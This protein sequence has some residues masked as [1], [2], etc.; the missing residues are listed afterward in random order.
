MPRVIAISMAGI[1]EQANIG[2]VPLLVGLILVIML[3]NFIIP[4]IMPK[5]AI[6]APVFIPLFVQLGVAPQTVLAAYRIGD[7]PTNV[8][9]PLMVYFPFIALV[10][11]R[12]QKDAGV[13]SI[14]ALMLP[15]TIIMA[16]AWTIF[17]VI[18]FV[19]GIPLG[20][21]YPVVMP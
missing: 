19:L 10:A 2:A 12:Y 4:G 7:S 18:W 21:G 15:Y 11:Q 20:P 3:L 8:I 17:F 13:G 6:F 5:W 16:I 1:L 9:T 14:I